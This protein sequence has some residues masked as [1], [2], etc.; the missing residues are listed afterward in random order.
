M[1]KFVTKASGKGISFSLK[2]GNGEIIATS[3]KSYPD[4]DAAKAAIAAMAACAPGAALED[5]TMQGF[6]EQ[7]GAKFELYTDKAG[8]FR[9]RLKAEDGTILAGSEGYTKKD[10]CKNGI[11]SVRKNADSPV[12]D[13]EPAE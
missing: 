7:Q 5:Q 2:A 11:E 1:G 3:S 12:A 10:S 6:A 13:P 8:E 4:L 9:F